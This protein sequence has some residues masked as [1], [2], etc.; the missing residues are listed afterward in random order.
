MSAPVLRGQTREG[1]L[2]QTQRAFALELHQGLKARRGAAL[3]HIRGF[4]I[5]LLQ[6]V[7]RKVNATSHRVFADI[8]NDVGQLKCQA[9]RVGIVKGLGMGVTKDAR[10]HLTHHACD[11]MTVL[12]QARKVEVTRLMQV[13]FTTLDD[14]QQMRG[15]DA[16]W[17]GQ[18]HQGTHDRVLRVA[19]KATRDLGKRYNINVMT[20]KNH[21]CCGHTFA[22]ID[23]ALH[24]QKTHGFKW[25]DIKRMKIA[26]YKAGTDIVNNAN[27]E[28]DYQ[29]KFSVQYVTAHAL[30]H[31]SV[32]L[33][34]FS[35]ERMKD[36][37]VRALLAKIEVEADPELSKI[38]RTSAPRMS[39][40]N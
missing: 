8:A 10:R 30:V 18:G 35:E 11:Q 14:C 3:Q 31:G 33:L 36:P 20:F 27:P 38:I 21:G 22:P 7:D 25:S 29:A 12:L 13:F 37:N 17:R 15:L 5:E 39:K 28:G 26:T 4:D 6:L 40:L 16:V 19:C 32:R 1:L 34:A 23:G 24:L 9:Q 2:V